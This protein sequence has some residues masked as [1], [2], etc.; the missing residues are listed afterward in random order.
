MDQIMSLRAK[1]MANEV[2]STCGSRHA[3]VFTDIVRQK[4]QLDE[5]MLALRTF[6]LRNIGR[7]M[8]MI[9]LIIQSVLHGKVPVSGPLH[10]PI[11]GIKHIRRLFSRREKPS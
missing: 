10:R 9:P 3:E 2:P 11:P 7:L 6:G 8:G 5:P 4:G 1:G